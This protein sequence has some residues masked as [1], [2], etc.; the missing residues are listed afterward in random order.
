MK[1]HVAM[2][3]C[4]RKTGSDKIMHTKESKRHLRR[5]KSKRAKRMFTSMYEMKRCDIKKPDQKPCSQSGE[6][7]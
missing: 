5:K 6:K 1:T 4:V 2:A 3:K 7:S